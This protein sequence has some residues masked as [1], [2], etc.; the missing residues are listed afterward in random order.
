MTV[1]FIFNKIRWRYA[2][3]Y[4]P[5]FRWM[6]FRDFKEGLD[7]VRFSSR[8]KLYKFIIFVMFLFALMLGAFDIMVIRCLI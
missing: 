6:G 3:H 5:R 1:Y 4:E 8:P 7:F 2:M